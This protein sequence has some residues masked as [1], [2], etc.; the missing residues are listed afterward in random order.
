MGK[1]TFEISVSLDGFV[2]G[3]EPSLDD[4]LGKGGEGLHEWVFGLDAWRKSHGLEGGDRT[5]DSELVEES[6]SRTGAVIMGRK[7]FSGG[8]GAWADDPNANGWWGDEPPFGVP[9]FVL[10]HHE[11]EPLAL[12]EGAEFNYVT[13]GPAAALERAREVAGERDVA[14]G[15]GAETI[16]QYLA[17]GEVDEFQLHVV[18][19]L[20]GGGVRLFEGLQPATGFEIDRVVASPAVTHV[21]YCVV[22]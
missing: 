19:L 9:V 11:R 18:P 1:L 2:A 8:A 3:P 21:R 5:A 7:M 13:E 17:A 15:G 12:R 22:R 16:G 20:L 4:P 14:I 6:L 10:T